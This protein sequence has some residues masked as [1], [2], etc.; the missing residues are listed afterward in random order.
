[1]QAGGADFTLTFR[2][3]TDAAATPSELDGVRELFSETEAFDGWAASWLERLARDSL[4]AEDR[5][6]SMRAANPAFIP[7]NHQ[8]EAALAAAVESDD[9]A[10][11]ERLLT[12]LARPYDDQP[13]VVAFA[14]PPPPSDRPYRTFCGT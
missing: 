8:V 5:A 11:F 10:P 4:S 9:F 6:A 13:D 12:V 7:R 2:R 3:L 14:L 1:M